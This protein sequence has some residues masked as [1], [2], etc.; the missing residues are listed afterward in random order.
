M[1]KAST[2]GVVAP[3]DDDLV[4]GTK[5]PDGSVRTRNYRWSGVFAYIRDKLGSA[6]QSDVADFTSAV[7]GAAAAAA[8]ADAQDSAD[9]AQTT[10]SGAATL[11]GAAGT[12]ADAAQA[13]VDAHEAATGTAVHGLGTIS[14]HPVADFATSGALTT[15][16][17]ARGS[18]DT[19]LTTAAAAAQADATAA[20][21]AG[22][23]EATTRGSADVE[24][25]RQAVEPRADLAEPFNRST[26]NA[27][28]TTRYLLSLG[29]STAYG[30]LG[31]QGTTSW[32]D[33]LNQENAQRYNNQPGG[34]GYKAVKTVLSSWSGQG[35]STPNGFGLQNGG[36]DLV[37][38]GEHI[39]EAVT[40]VAGTAISLIVR[41]HKANGAAGQLII[42]GG[43]PVAF[44]CL[45]A[46]LSPAHRSGKI[47]LTVTGLKNTTHSIQVKHNDT[48]GKVL[49]PEGYIVHTGTET[50][51]QVVLNGGIGGTTTTDWL[52]ATTT[53][54]NVKDWLAN[55]GSVT[56][57]VI[58]LLGTNDMLLHPGL[59]PA[60]PA[61]NL[62]TDIFP[63]LRAADT[64]LGIHYLLPY[65]C[66]NGTMPSPNLP[67]VGFSVW[68]TT[69]VP[70][71]KAAAVAA[72]VLSTD[73]TAYFGDVSIE[74]GNSARWANLDGIHLLG[75]GQRAQ[76]SLIR[77]DWRSQPA[78]TPAM[79]TD[80][81][82]AV[83]PLVIPTT[84]GMSIKGEVLSGIA[85]A[86]SVYEG[87]TRSAS[88]SSF[89]GLGI[90]ALNGGSWGATYVSGAIATLGA[91][92]LR[93]TTNPSTVDALSRKGY[94]DTAD[95][96]AL[97]KSANLSDVAN[98][99]TA[100]TNLAHDRSYD[101]GTQVVS[102]IVETTVLASATAHRIPAGRI[103]ANG[104]AW[105]LYLHQRSGQ[106]GAASTY[107]W[108]VKVGGSTAI[109][110]TTASM[111][112]SATAE[113]GLIIVLITFRTVGA[114]GT[115]VATP[116][117]LYQAAPASVNGATPPVGGIEPFTIDTTANVDVN[118]TVQNS[119]SGAAV[120][121]GSQGSHLK[122]L[123]RT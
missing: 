1:A 42:D 28:T 117:Y 17:A 99:G 15:E 16:A 62:Q 10:A 81:T 78:D 58:V 31:V 65:Y 25:T 114:S 8:A 27:F 71:L 47:V 105:L 111:A 120:G 96:F 23:T 61:A 54:Q 41:E 80:G 91:G 85:A 77:R 46:G 6:A 49:S 66:G 79:R 36:V 95:A 122:Q 121:G 50:N 18:A 30:S 84:I 22:V 110:F 52:S 90:F 3:T 59:G 82:N 64:D 51:G 93:T 102:S 67:G 21:A 35:T 97:L 109:D 44:T 5:D 83:L 13:D 108:R 87:T 53:A 123:G 63:W 56:D 48:T 115:V 20:L 14:T 113:Y 40:Q 119:A 106:F 24:L 116:V 34:S 19:T 32:F 94:V 70:P 39:D 86:W 88:Q 74:G 26:Q 29:D 112:S 73:Q 2:Y 107:R 57:G 43:A 89:G 92:E 12:A 76:A 98:A 37:T 104:Q 68:K 45:N 4:L 55:N 60:V 11:A 103:T 118:V 101:A 38:N 75:E 7:D 100:A 33:R 72:A 69:W 9:T